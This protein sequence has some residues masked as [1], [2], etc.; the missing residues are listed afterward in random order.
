MEV[1]KI[2]K[3]SETSGHRQQVKMLMKD[4]IIDD[5]WI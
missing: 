3:E 2:C 1:M 5:L 4:D